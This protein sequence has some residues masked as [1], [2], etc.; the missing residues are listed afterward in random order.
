MNLVCASRRA[1][2][3]WSG[4][5]VLL[6]FL[7]AVSPIRP[8]TRGTNQSGMASRRV[9]CVKSNIK[10]K[11][12]DPRRSAPDFHVVAKPSSPRH[13]G[14]CHEKLPALLVSNSQGLDNARIVRI[15]GGLGERGAALMYP[16]EFD[17][18]TG[19]HLEVTHGKQEKQAAGPEANG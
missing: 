19:H 17:S 4:L 10:G 2:W 11:G 16:W 13:L 3:A 15:P 18:L 14:M 9:L 7:L 12:A 5:S 1:G 6:L 8:C